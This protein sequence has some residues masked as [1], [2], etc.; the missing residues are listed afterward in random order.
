MAAQRD[1]MHKNR[2]HHHLARLHE[3]RAWERLAFGPLA[4]TIGGLAAVI[5]ESK[6]TLPYSQLLKGA[7]CLR[8]AAPYLTDKRRRRR[9]T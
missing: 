1:L 2:T 9:P 8:E 6:H 4:R 7:V 3:R 5:G